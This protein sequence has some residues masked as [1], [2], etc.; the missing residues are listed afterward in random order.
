MSVALCVSVTQLLDI[1]VVFTFQLLWAMLLWK[2]LSANLCV[3]SV[4]VLPFITCKIIYFY[5][6]RK[7][8]SSQAELFIIL[9]LCPLSPPK[10]NWLFFFF[11]LPSVL[12][13][14][15]SFSQ[16]LAID[17]KVK[18]THLSKG[19]Q[20]GALTSYHPGQP[21]PLHRTFSWAISIWV[22]LGLGAYF[23]R[24]PVLLISWFVTQFFI[25]QTRHFALS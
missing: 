3:D 22:C 20:L 17:R 18:C 11:F 10:L 14:V 12:L 4:N 16:S 5:R 21:S 23:I 6:V 1:L 24:Q 2:H 15:D 9:V 8:K 25:F 13:S 7:S 19:Q